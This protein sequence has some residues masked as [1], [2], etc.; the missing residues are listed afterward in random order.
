MSL[1]TIGIPT[2][3]SEKRI[4]SLLDSILGQK[5]GDFKILISDNASTDG[6]NELCRD[7]AAKDDRIIVFRQQVRLCMRDNFR[8]VLNKAN[9][10]YFSW[11]Q[12]DDL[13][14]HEWG[15]NLMSKLSQ[16]PKI[17]LA[18]SDLRFQQDDKV[19]RTMEDFDLSDN[20]FAR[21]RQIFSAYN[22]Q[23]WFQYYPFCGIWRTAHLK[24]L[25]FQLTDIY[26][27]ENLLGTDKLLLFKKELDNDYIFISDKLFTKRKLTAQST[28]RT[29]ITYGERYRESVLMIAQGRQYMLNVID[30]SSYSEKV[31]NRLAEMIDSILISDVVRAGWARRLKWRLFPWYKKRSKKNALVSGSS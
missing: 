13:V 31:K 4:S 22:G 7:Y 23:L 15:N 5:F 29:E 30:S 14:D 8:F 12:D 24:R 19:I 26:Q 28:Y 18:F 20:L 17:N 27:N 3:N 16:E 6:T 10:E 2:L 25:F 21:L 1:L 11:Q 9:S